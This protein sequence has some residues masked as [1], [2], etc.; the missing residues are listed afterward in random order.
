MNTFRI[1]TLFVTLALLAFS[2]GGLLMGCGGSAS[3]PPVPKDTV[4][5]TL[6][7]SGTTGTVTKDPVTLTFIFSEDV[8]STFTASDVTVT[9][10]TAAASVTKTDA[11]HYTLVV[12][13]AVGSAGTMTI[14][15]A[16]GTFTDVAGNA[17]AAAATTTQAYD[18]QA[19]TVTI[20]GTSATVARGAVPLTFTFSEDIGTTFSASDVTVT[21]GSAASSVTKVDATH[22]TLVATPTAGITGTMG[23]SV[24]IGAFSDL[25]GNASTVAAT[26][27]QSFDTTIPILTSTVFTD[28]YAAGLSFVGFGGSTNSVTV[29]TAEFHS[30]SASLKIVVPATNYT[31]GAIVAATAKDLSAF[32]VLTFWAKAS[33]AAT[34]NVAGLGNDASSTVYAAESTGLVLTTA[35]Q[36]F[37]IPIPVPAKATAMTGLFHFA[38]GS[39]EGAYT[40][41]LDDIQYEARTGSSVPTA[42]GAAITWPV[43]N[44]QVGQTSQLSPASNTVT[45]SF[46]VLPNA[47]KLT[48]VGFRYFTLA[49]SASSVATVSADGLVTGVSAGTASVTGSLGSLAVSGSSAVTVVA[50]IA[51]PTTLPPVPAPPSGS[52]VISLYSSVTGGY[53][54]GASDQSAKVDTWLASWSAGAGGA[55][56]PITVGAQTASPR[57]YTMTASANYIGIETIGWSTATPPVITGTHEID[58]SGMTHLHV[59]VWTPNNSSNLQFKMVDAGTNL[60]PE[61]STD[62]VGIATLTAGSTPALAT[63]K[64]LSYDLAIGADFPG[65]TFP[66]G[67]ASNLKHVAQL[68]IVAPNG[69]IVY[70][71]NLYFWGPAGGGGGTAT[72]PTSGA[73]APTLAAASVI[74]LYTSTN[75]YTNAPVSDWNPNWGQGGSMS[76]FVAGSKTVKKLDLNLYQGIAISSNGGDAAGTGVLNV[77]GK[78]VLHVSYWT[79]N[80][81]SFRFFPINATAETPISSGTL[82]QGAWTDLELT[83]PAGFDLSTLRQLKFDT[84]TA[85]VIYLDNIYFHAASGGGVATAPTTVPAAPSVAAANVISLHNSSNV[86]VNASV[87]DWNPNWGQGGSMADYAVGTKTVKKLDLNLYQGIAISSNGGDAAGTGVLNITGKSTLHVSYWTANGTSFRFFPINATAETPISSGTLVQGAWTDLELT[88]PAGFDLA[89]IRQL[90]FDTTTAG[91][92]YLDNIYFHAGSGGTATAP[93]TAPAA[94]SL[95]AASVISL[96]NSSSTYTNAPVSDWNPNWGQ[97]GSLIDY[98]AGSKTVKKLD[99]NLYQGI[100]ISSNGGDAAGTGVLNITGKSTLHVSYWTANGTSFRFFPIN[101]TAETPI[102]SGTLVQG[103]WTNLEIAI[104]AGFDLT[105]IRQL[106][107]DTTAAQVIYLDNIYFH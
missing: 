35:W 14:S 41:W 95:A 92:I 88:I 105:T 90:K 59:D 6:A 75:S 53:N 67:N 89:T 66:S 47:G 5:P 15:V 81:T 71:D 49:S 31:G 19:P 57:K 29:D 83:I 80:G 25:A 96:F 60:I 43:T 101:A 26:A 1:R 73:S 65:N 74:S 27:S 12:T 39:D 106:K 77:T 82:V 18:T 104:P 45:Y 10:G 33:K 52:S 99:L 102:S 84:T 93:T 64:W 78:D 11:T 98:V 58:I 17:S 38:E 23:I 68:V 13:P 97:G 48:G 32:N 8:G 94:P 22:Y 16:A 46:P 100:A 69:G 36:Q 44:I 42:V 30:G 20:T 37:I 34:L 50:S 55:P 79:A 56:F 28:T 61:E 54:G 4:A 2:L 76:D 51:V 107:F 62:P 21:N 24:A 91:V 3:A 9:N 87:S 7:I 72:A 86:Y 103:A 70:L 63:G 40:I 85:Q